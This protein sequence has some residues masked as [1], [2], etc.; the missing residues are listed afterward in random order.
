MKFY[1]KKPIPVAAVKCEK[2]NRKEIIELLQ[3]G[4]TKWEELPDGFMVHSWEGVEPVK[5]GSNYWII[6][7]VK[8]ECYPCEGG[9]FEQSYEE[10]ST[11]NHIVTISLE[12]YENFKAATE[13]VEKNKALYN[14][15]VVDPLIKTLGIA[16][17]SM[18]GEAICNCECKEEVKVMEDYSSPDFDNH[19]KLYFIFTPLPK[20]RY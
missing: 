12:E 15:L 6:K 4:T 10:Y 9:V 5:Y 3:Q 13:T 8:G 1:T 7:G 16:E 11:Q 2:E 17:G 19:N 18:W 20:I 14:K